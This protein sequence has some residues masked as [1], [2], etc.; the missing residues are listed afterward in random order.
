[1]R[2]ARPVRGLMTGA[3][4]E[5]GSCRHGQA[6]RPIKG[7]PPREGLAMDN[8]TFALEV[9]QR[10]AGAAL[11]WLRD[12]LTIAA[13]ATPAVVEMADAAAPTIA[14]VRMTSGYSQVASSAERIDAMVAI[15]AGEGRFRLADR[16]ERI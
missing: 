8:R 4:K 9:E 5:K 15:D 12:G 13:T 3:T 1:M 7:R 16:W 6:G 14:G 2:G 11:V 10:P